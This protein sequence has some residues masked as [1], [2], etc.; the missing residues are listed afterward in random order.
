MQSYGLNGLDLKLL[1]Y[2]DYKNGFFIE[3]GANDGLSQS[4][5]A[6]SEFHYDWKGLLIEPIFNKYLDCKKNRKNSIVENY[7]LV[8]KNYNKKTIRGNFD[9][10]GYAE[11]LTA[12]VC[13]DGDYNDERLMELK[14]NLID[15]NQWAKDN[16]YHPIVEVPAITI[17]ELLK[18][19]KIEKIDLFSLDVEGYEISVL[20][21]L[22]FLINRPKYF[23]IE[24]TYDE[25]KK[26]ITEYMMS[27][28]YRMVE[29]FTQ[30][31]CLWIDDK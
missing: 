18:K 24:M 31:D 16:G 21:G 28:N 22:D 12:C 5:T 15:N 14:Q 29:Y 6:L 23:L 11:S 30:N 9:E 20:N 3:A 26:T 13:D 17:G 25:R 2:I 27:K 8:G 10:N 4:N 1:K 7:A 19:H